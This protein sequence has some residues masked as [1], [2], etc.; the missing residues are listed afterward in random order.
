[1][2]S[3]T[4]TNLE[5]SVLPQSFS[6]IALNTLDSSVFKCSTAKQHSNYANMF[7]E[8]W[9]VAFCKFLHL[10]IISTWHNQETQA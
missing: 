2:R 3:R 1:M 4:P 9:A 7:F 5:K 10:P 8:L 6:D